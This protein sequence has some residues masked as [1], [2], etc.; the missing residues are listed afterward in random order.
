MKLLKKSISFLVILAMLF[1]MCITSVFAA[2]TVYSNYHNIYG[3]IE[4]EDDTVKIE[5]GAIIKAYIY[6]DTN[7]F[8]SENV[9]AFHLL[10]SVSDNLEIISSGLAADEALLKLPADES[11]SSAI[12]EE[13]ADFDTMLHN[14]KTTGQTIDFT[15]VVF[16]NSEG[17]AI[18][19]DEDG[20][21]KLI[22]LELKVIGSG[23]LKI[24]LDDSFV[25]HTFTTD[26][27]KKHCMTDVSFSKKGYAENDDGV[28]LPSGTVVGGGGV[29]SNKTDGKIT[30][31]TP[32]NVKDTETTIDEENK[33][34]TIEVP[35]GTDLT[36]VTLDVDYVGKS[37][38][39]KK[40][41]A[42]DLSE[43]FEIKVIGSN[44]KEI[45]YTINVKHKMSDTPV[46]P[47]DGIIFSDV[48]V[49]RRSHDMIKDLYPRY[50]FTMDMLLQKRDGVN[51]LN[52]VDFI[53][54]N[55]NLL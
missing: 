45:A 31:V 38:S 50:L 29:V 54:N 47:G 1:S 14:S 39:I 3:K 10:G 20:F 49:D 48:E 25:K 8:G 16:K 4:L 32:K 53:Y 22:W 28:T 6:A 19:P 24:N 5:N 23:D 36:N 13:Y 11:P 15:A 41:E 52:I 35:F 40:G 9:T 27:A 12:P 17:N 26:N 21:A 55:K 18:V 2:E 30:D 46:V 43:P 37:I 33:T 7:S 51:H 34:I 42:V 44:G